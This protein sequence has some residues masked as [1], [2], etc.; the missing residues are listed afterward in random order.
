MATQTQAGSGDFVNNLGKIYGI[1]TG[2]FVAFIILVAILEQVGVPNRILGY[3]FVFFT[4]AVYAIIGVATLAG[5][6]TCSGHGASG[7]ENPPLPV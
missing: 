7:A 6:A 1:Y 5:T 3:M 4:L 2:G